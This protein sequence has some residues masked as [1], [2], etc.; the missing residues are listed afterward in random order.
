MGAKSFHL[1]VIVSS[2][3]VQLLKLKRGSIW[4]ISIW[5][6]EV[7]EPQSRRSGRSGIGA[8]VLPYGPLSPRKPSSSASPFVGRPFP[9]ASYC[10]L[11]CG[12]LNSLKEPKVLI[13]GH[14]MKRR[15]INSSFIEHELASPGESLSRFPE[16][17]SPQPC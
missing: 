10:G 15:K 3:A 11:A 14:Q 16:D 13:R 17:G 2:S 7:R 8:N 9:C 5:A 4:D 1:L 12:F 6:H